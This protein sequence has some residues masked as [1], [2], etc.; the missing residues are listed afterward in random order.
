[1]TRIRSHV[2]PCK[3]HPPRVVGKSVGPHPMSL[4]SQWLGNETSSFP[5]F[6]PRPP[7]RSRIE[8][9]ELAWGDRGRR[10][11]EGRRHNRCSGGMGRRNRRFVDRRNAATYA[12][13]PSDFLR[14][15]ERDAEDGEGRTWMRVDERA[16][17]EEEGEADV[18]PTHED[19]TDREN[20]LPWSLRREM[21]SMGL[22]DDGYDYLQHLRETGVGARTLLVAP[23]PP[24]AAEDERAIDARRRK[25]DAEATD[26]VEEDAFETMGMRSALQDAVVAA[27]DAATRA[28]VHDVVRAMAQEEC[29]ELQDDFVKLALQ[30]LSSEDER[31]EAGTLQRQHQRHAM[32]RCPRRDE[33]ADAFEAYLSRLYASD[34]E[35]EAWEESTAET[36]AKEVPG[37][38][39]MRPPTAEEIASREARDADLAKT[40]TRAWLEAHVQASDA[41]RP[42][43][44]SDSDEDR[45]FARTGTK[46]VDGCEEQWGLA[47]RMASACRMANAAQP[48]VISTPADMHIR[49]SKRNGLP[50]RPRQATYGKESDQD[51]FQKGNEQLHAREGE[52]MMD[53]E[54]LGQRRKGETAEEK[55][56]RKA[57]AKEIKRQARERKAD[58][59]A[60]KKHEKKTPPAPPTRIVPLP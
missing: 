18:R 60:Q 12:L 6:F 55:K 17:D 28:D 51:E 36:R 27:M 44:T 34:S 52:E 46:V 50:A 23:G 5:V 19:A 57:A 43:S 3:L 29:E 7:S 11:G 20:V 14:P 25:A 4:P 32:S 49:I 39:P 48:K 45:E 56:R 30:E 13:V 26:G 37:L 58:M 2:Y 41:E 54:G 40:A 1:M 10:D 53:E 21:L 22:P 38:V 24:R 9:M 47:A 16:T 35:D 33:D 59:K 8:T 31:N 15:E 42:P